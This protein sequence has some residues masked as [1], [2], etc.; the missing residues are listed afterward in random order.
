MFKRLV[1]SAAPL[2]VLAIL[3]L[4]DLRVSEPQ[5]PTLN[6]RECPHEWKLRRT[7]SGPATS[8]IANIPEFH[9][10]QRFIVRKDGTLKYDSLYAIF[11][12]PQLDSLDRRLNT[13]DSLAQ[14]RGD[15]ALAA[16][17][18]YTGH[19][20][21]SPLGIKTDYSCLY[22]F[23]HYDANPGW[24]AILVSESTPNFRCGGE[25]NPGAL[26]GK[27]LAVRFTTFPGVFKDEDYPPVARWD[28]D[29]VNLKQYIGI[30]CGSAWC[31]IGE[32]GFVSS[33]AYSADHSLPR[34]FRR[35]RMIKGW[36][37]EQWLATVAE[38]TVQPTRIK[39]TIFPD[40]NLGKYDNMAGF[41][42]KPP[43]AQIA[44]GG[45]ATDYKNK[46]NLDPAPVGGTHLNTMT[47]CQG[48]KFSCLGWPF[49]QWPKNCKTGWYAT[50]VALDGSKRHKCVTRWPAPAGIHVWA[51]ARWRWLAND[52]TTWKRCAEGCC[53]VH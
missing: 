42:S 40:E 7:G 10:C 22:L 38:G 39:G 26:S 51:T 29:S 36:Y 9:D 13:L 47:M 31:E 8:P 18:I 30:K 35:T 21:Y 43:V 3:P 44:I 50:I 11:A 32:S 20:Q 15:N 48:S 2:V 24:R 4:I 14:K 53:E 27:E 37:D 33:E 6:R 52:E 34:E 17:E 28:W 5:D 19:G 45:P 49:W 23:H 41:S 12:D 16:A 46:F 1:L 25:V